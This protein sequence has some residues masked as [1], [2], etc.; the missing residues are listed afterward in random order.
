[1]EADTRAPSP[2]DALKREFGSRLQAYGTDIRR[3]GSYV[4]LWVQ[5]SV[6]TVDNHALDAAV[7][8]ANSLGLPVYAYFALV[9][10]Y[11]GANSRH[12]AF[13]L[14]GLTDL[15]RSLAEIGIPLVTD[16]ADPADGVPAA[17]TEAAC[18]VTDRGYTRIQREWR[19]KVADR[20]SVPLIRLESDAVVPVD[21]ASR[22]EEYAAATLRPKLQRLIDL[23]LGTGGSPHPRERR[24][25]LQPLPFRPLRPLDPGTLLRNPAEAGIDTSVAPVDWIVGGENRAHAA[26]EEFIEHGLNH[27]AEARNDP[28]LDIQSNLGPYLHFGQIS[29]LTAA[30]RVMRA[31]LD[32]PALADGAAAFLEQL[33]VR[34][35][36][37][38]NFVYYNPVY[39]A[40]AAAPE[41]AAANLDSHAADPRPAYYSRDQLYAGETDDVYWNAAQRELL[42]KGKMHGYMRMYWGKKLLEW[43]TD[44]REAWELLVEL[45]DAYSLDGRDPNGYAGIAWVFGKHDRPF[46]ERPCFGKLRPMGAKGLKRK[47]EMELYLARNSADPG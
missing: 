30:Q 43:M 29:P 2:L 4:L 19:R 22:K 18:V 3:G 24:T 33:I 21:Q 7:R 8:I 15:E 11:P 42:T 13:L 23:Y 44:W 10:D 45:N 41:C 47:F 39:D 25:H 36:L 26:L 16:R 31:S 46:P 14:Q 6:R 35:E 40:P 38:I 27:Y 9:P 37:A 20:L 12:F 32:T 5:Q 17:A 28:G 34:R 1:M